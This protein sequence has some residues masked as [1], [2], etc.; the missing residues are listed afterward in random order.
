MNKSEIIT[1]S[2]VAITLKLS[3]TIYRR[4]TSPTCLVA[5]QKMIDSLQIT[6]QL[7]PIPSPAPGRE[8]V[9]GPNGTTTIHMHGIWATYTAPPGTILHNFTIVPEPNR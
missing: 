5:V 1:L 6:S 8:I 2:M 3:G 9:I 4:T 7:V